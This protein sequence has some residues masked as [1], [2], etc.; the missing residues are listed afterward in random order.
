[1]W[2]LQL[3][4]VLLLAFVHG[5]DATE[6]HLRRTEEGGDLAPEDI[7]R[8]RGGFDI[9]DPFSW[10]GVFDDTILCGLVLVHSDIVLTTASCVDDEG[11]PGFVRIGSLERDTGG[12]VS[13]I[14]RGTIHPD[15]N[16]RPEDGADIAVMKLDNALTNTV[17]LLNEDPRVPSGSD[18]LF[19]AGHGLV[20]DATTRNNLQGL[21][22]DNVENC[23]ERSPSAYNPVFHFCGDASPERGTCPGDAGIPILI[24]GTRIVVGLNS[25]SDRPCETQ[26]ID[27]YTRM[28]TYAPWVHHLAVRNQVATSACFKKCLTLSLVF[29]VSR[30][31]HHQWEV[32]SIMVDLCI[33]ICLPN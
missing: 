8:I 33:V 26:T 5:G 3:V 18:D 27:V 21:F 25:F 9:T 19:M 31:L 22:L 16:G 20:N 32:L 15:W 4:L 17:A 12:T 2:S 7:A 10:L 1:M 11:F 13:Q 6:S 23:F 24:P 28:S 29:L 30:V 14:R